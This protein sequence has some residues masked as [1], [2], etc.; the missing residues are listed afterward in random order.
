MKDTSI[1]K[2][3]EV[4]N[5]LTNP[6]HTEH[7]N[8]SLASL[9]QQVIRAEAISKPRGSKFD[10]Y[11]YVWKDDFRPYMTGVFHEDGNKVASDAHILIAMKADYPAEYE[12]KTLKKDGAFVEEKNGHYPK[13]R[14]VIPDLSMDYHPYEIDP[15]K[16]YDWLEVKRAEYKTENGKGAKWCEQ[17]RVRV[18]PAVLKA[19]FFGKMLT[20]MKELGANQVWA[21]DAWRPVA[22][23]SDK[24]ICILMPL[25]AGD[26]DDNMLTLA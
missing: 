14:S 25:M 13:W 7:T 17:W 11:N 18:G 20:A 6:E 26:V 10:F 19:E 12:G 5:A 16:F 22:V 8:Q 1:K 9:I 23:K 4:Y 21:K 15:Q 24:G 3:S 2:L